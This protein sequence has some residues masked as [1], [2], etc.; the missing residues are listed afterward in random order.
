MRASGCGTPIERGSSGLGP[1]PTG[2]DAALAQRLAGLARDRRHPAR[3]GLD[4]ARRPAGRVPGQPG[5]H[6]SLVGRADDPVARRGALVPRRALAIPGGADLRDPAA[7]RGAVSRHRGRIHGDQHLPAPD[8]GADPALV[9]VQGDRLERAIDFTALLVLGALLL[10]FHSARLPDW[11]R[12]GAGV[13]AALGC[14]PFVL[15]VALRRD[16]ER[17]L[18]TLRTALGVLPGR[19]AE[20]LV[21]ALEQVCHGL[22]ALR[23]RR[24]VAMVVLWSAILWGVLFAAPFAIGFAA[25]GIDLP[26]ADM[27]LAIYTV[28]VLTALAVAVPS[29]PGFFGVYHFACREG[30]ALFG[31]SSATAVAYGTVAHLAYWLP[32]TL[33]G[34]LAV[35]RSGGRVRDLVAPT[36]R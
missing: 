3:A 36:A 22:V 33:A 19:L 1:R 17:T 18:R 32:V 24:A 7:A 12:V 10:W 34:L 14:L 25:L 4:A 27:L 21:D 6:E 30:L 35:A 5:A 20:P 16:Q 28:H 11:V 15:A 2:R 31:V 8:R 9:P 29:A 13:F 26:A 23:G